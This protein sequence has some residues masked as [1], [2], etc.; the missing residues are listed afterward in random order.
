MTRTYA[1][2]A[3]FEAAEKGQPGLESVGLWEGAAITS[4]IA[5]LI[6]R[7]GNKNELV[8]VTLG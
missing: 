4:S 5:V 2:K 8:V 1:T 6:D 7:L 3:G